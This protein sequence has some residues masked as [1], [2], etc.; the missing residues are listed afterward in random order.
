MEKPLTN[1]L[2]LEQGREATTKFDF[3]TAMSTG[4]VNVVNTLTTVR[5]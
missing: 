1:P 4:L 2:N 3:S 5:Q